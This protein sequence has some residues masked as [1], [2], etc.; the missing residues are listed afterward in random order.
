MI[1]ES[2]AALVKRERDPLE[3]IIQEKEPQANRYE[4]EIEKK[5]TSLIAKYQ[6]KAKDLRI[7]LMVFRMVNDLERIGDIAVN[8]SESAKFLI[9]REELKPLIDIPRMAE[10]ARGMLEDALKS[11]V[12]EDA[13]LA[14]KVCERDDIVDALRDQ[15][16]RELVTYMSADYKNIERALHLIRISRN[17]ERVADHATNIAEEVIYMVEGRIIK[18]GGIN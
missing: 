6:P 12:E 17:L 9:E 7:I 4:I 1:E 18:H 11:F 3:K 5:C 13:S 15:I 14:E 10:E 2:I 8:I 16:V